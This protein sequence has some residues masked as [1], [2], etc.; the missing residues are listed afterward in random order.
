M[1]KTTESAAPDEVARAPVSL[2]EFCVRLSN[3]DRRVE[4]IGGFA[5]SERAAGRTMDAESAF[6]TRYA[7]FVTKP[8]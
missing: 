1:A 8:A 7:A 2:D 4:M 3:T 5:A 6:A